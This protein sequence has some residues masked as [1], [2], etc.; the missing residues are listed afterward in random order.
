[1]QKIINFL[2]G[3]VA[4]TVTGAFPERFLN[5]CA[6]NGV[7]FW[8]LE[9]RD[10][11]TL[12]LRVAREHAKRLKKLAERVQCDTRA[13]RRM[14]VP[15][16]LAK[17][18]KR[19]A[20]LLGLVLSIAAVCVLSQFVL[21]ID[22]TGNEKVSTAEILSQLRRCGL[23]VGSYGPG[24]DGKAVSYEALLDLPELSWMAVNLHGTRAEV[25][26][27]EKLPAPAVVDRTKPS[28]VVATATGI[29]TS[30]EPQDGRA[31]FRPGQTVLEGEVLISGIMDI[32]EPAWSTIDLGVRVVHAMGDVHARTWRTLTAEIPLETQVKRYTG[33]TKTRLALTFLDQRVNFYGNAFISMDRY[34]KITSTHSLTLPAGRVMPLALVTERYRAYE[35]ETAT[36]DAGAA[37]ALLKE[38][39]EL[40]LRTLV[41]DGEVTRMDF[42][43]REQNGILTVTL[44]AECREQIGKIVEYEGLVGENPPGVPGTIYPN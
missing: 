1:M 33:E 4:F 10:E 44:L 6:Q 13:D 21:T 29:V 14:G 8:D 22:V 5:L 36:L 26:V 43:A 3:S 25:I 39:L 2:R 24:L 34:D 37:E 31:L 35:T 20:L 27:R 32:K 28:N 42:A 9:W 16:F 18:K 40:R 15:F 19:Y 12:H 38:C 7:G 23:K 11:H 41:G 17:F 30:I